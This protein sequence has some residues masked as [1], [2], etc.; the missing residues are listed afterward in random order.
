MLRSSLT[1]TIAWSE[2]GPTKV[3]IAIEGGPV[4]VRTVNVR[5]AA[6]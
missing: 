3:R 1:D 2:P 6:R 4:I 5:P